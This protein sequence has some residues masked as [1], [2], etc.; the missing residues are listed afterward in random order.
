MVKVKIIKNSVI[1]IGN[2]DGI[3]KGHQDIFGIG[4]KIAKQKKKKFGV[5]TFSPMSSEFFQK[6]KKNLRI[7]SDDIKID[8]F[9]KK[10]NRFFLYM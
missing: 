4:K 10:Q 6:E 5:L 9:K 3:H 2:F 1:A 8:L 7:T